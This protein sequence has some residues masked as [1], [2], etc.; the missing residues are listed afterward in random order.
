MQN[1]QVSGNTIDKKE[2]FACVDRAETRENS[3]E[4]SYPLGIITK[5]EATPV[6]TGLARPHDFVLQDRISQLL[7]H[8]RVSKCLKHKV[9]KMEV[10]QI[11]FVRET[12]K[13]YWDNVQRCGSVFM[14]PVCSKKISEA[15]RV[16]LAKAIKVWKDKGNTVLLLT[17]TNSHDIKDKLK[18]LLK[19]QK[20]AI[21][22][23]FGDG[24]GK[25]ILGT[26]KI[27]GLMRR[28]GHIRAV[29]I[30]YGQNGWHPHFHILLF[31]E[32]TFNLNQIKDFKN[33]LYLHWL[34]CCKKAKL[35]LPDE[36]HGLDLRDGNY[37][38][39]YISKWGLEH[40]MTKNISKKGRN[41]SYNP[42]DLANLSFKDEKI[43]GRKPSMLFKEYAENFKG[44]RQLSW[45]KG[46]KQ[47][48]L[49]DNKTDEQLAQ[50]DLNKAIPLIKVSDKEFYLIKKAGMRHL[51]LDYARNDYLN[52]TLDC[53]EY[54]N[55]IFELLQEKNYISPYVLN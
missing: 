23:F 51:F 43:N 14:C 22:S 25:K 18:D 53:G 42:F 4:K 9:T 52:N 17:L 21:K 13:T 48:L 47:A 29:E 46:L 32:G 8:E 37:A 41:Q 16:E 10:R 35:S 38:A 6:N 1:L 20:K 30:T 54:L 19:G 5:S 33:K 11:V 36:K 3:N 45:S 39:K 26:N 34:N 55:N 31:L 15:R 24:L 27:K 2:A 7:P 12:N 49:I 50:Q 40:E 28:F 44:T